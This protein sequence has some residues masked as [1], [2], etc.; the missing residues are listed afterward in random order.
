MTILFSGSATAACTPSL[1]R[2]WSTFHQMKT[3]VSSSKSTSGVVSKLLEQ[4]RRQRS[5]EIVRD[6][7]HAQQVLRLA[8]LL[9]LARHRHQLGHRLAVLGD[10]DFFAS[11]ST[12]HQRRE[13]VLGFV[14]VED[15]GHENLANL[16][17][18][19]IPAANP[20]KSS[21]PPSSS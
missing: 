1:S 20:V 15:L 11:G 16:A 6:I 19:Y 13:L 4:F 14:E 3:C 17:K 18:F 8:W 7:G 2:V 12:I 21:A 9:F 10:D 5:V